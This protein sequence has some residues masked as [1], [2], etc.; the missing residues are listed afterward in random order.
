MCGTCNEKREEDPQSWT[1]ST[2][3]KT[4]ITCA[5][6]RGVQVEEKIFP[7]SEK[8]DGH[9]YTWRSASK[10]LYMGNSSNSWRREQI[11]SHG[12][13]WNVDN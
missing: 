11:K 2:R 12:D 1:S 6:D 13:G 10:S 7:Q 4:N 9:V 5:S 8:G 3:K